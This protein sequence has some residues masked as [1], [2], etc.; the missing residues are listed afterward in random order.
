MIFEKVE[1]YC[2]AVSISIAAFERLCKIGNG[3]VGRWR[4]GRS[5]PTV[6]T[7]LKIEHVTGIPMYIWLS[8]EENI[9]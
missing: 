3:T 6:T 9:L 4:N 7:L 5:K 1:Q 8:K 2:E